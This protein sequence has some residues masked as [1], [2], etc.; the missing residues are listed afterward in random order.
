DVRAIPMSDGGPGFVDAV[1]TIPEAHP[2]TVVVPG[3]RGRSVPARIAVHRKVAYVESAMACGAQALGPDP[4]D[5]LASGT[6]GVGLLVRACCELPVDTVV[7][8]LGGSVTNDGGMGALSALGAVFR[9]EVGRTLPGCGADLARVASVDLSGVP[10]ALSSRVQLVLAADVDS[11]LLGATGA[12]RGFGPQKGADREMVGRLE[13]GMGLLAEVLE[14]AAGRGRLREAPG[15][16]AAGGLGFGLMALG[17]SR[18]PGFDV[19]AELV[20]LTAGIGSADLVLTGEGRLD[21][22]SLH[23]KVVHGVATAC[24]KQARPCW[25]IAGAIDDPDRVVAELGLA[26]ASSLTEHAGSSARARAEAA[27]VLEQLSSQ[28]AATTRPGAGGLV[29][30]RREERPER[31]HLQP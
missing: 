2:H 28:V 22:Q 7:V 14:R 3:P 21:W 6:H 25:V 26:G 8:G 23:G 18:R 29:R 5:P 4:L 27:V 16:G 24:A 31:A 30:P 10:A 20:E 11:A 17:A 9:D 15:S 19:V 1:L 13:S 12:S